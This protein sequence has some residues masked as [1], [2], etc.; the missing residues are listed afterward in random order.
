MANMHD[1]AE[2]AA[3]PSLFHELRPHGVDTVTLKRR[4]PCGR[5]TESY[6]SELALEEEVIGIVKVAKGQHWTKIHQRVR[7]SHQQVP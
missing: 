3:V 4:V 2:A 5:G 1:S 6:S 7:H